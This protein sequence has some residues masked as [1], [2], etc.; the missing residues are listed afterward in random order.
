M[1]KI[2]SMKIKNALFFCMKLTKGNLRKQKT[3]EIRQY[4]VK[5]GQNG[6]MQNQKSL[7][8]LQDFDQNDRNT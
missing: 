7:E 1:I 3:L 5:N 6:T 8:I 2:E 4:L